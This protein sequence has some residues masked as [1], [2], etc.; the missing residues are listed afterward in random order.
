[1]RSCAECYSAQWCNVYGHYAECHFTK[2]NDIMLSFCCVV[3]TLGVII[4]SVILRV[5]IMNAFML[6]DLTH[7]PIITSVIMPSTIM[8]TAIML[9][10]IML[11]A[12]CL[13]LLYQVSLCLV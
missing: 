10:F 3:V 2:F 5:N 1:L 4:L 8:P 11:R 12:I 13:I 6:I 9:S 7:T